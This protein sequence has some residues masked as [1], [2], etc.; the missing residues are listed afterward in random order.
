IGAMLERELDQLVSRCF[1]HALGGAGSMNRRGLNVFV[2]REGVH[3]G[4]V[5]QE[6][7]G[8]VRVSEEARQAQRM[9]AV[10]AERVGKPRFLF[11]QDAQAWSPAER[12]GFEDVELGLRGQELRDPP[13]LSLVQ[14]LEEL[15]H[16]R[17]N[18]ERRRSLST[19]PPVWHSGQ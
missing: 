6:E 10:A 2:P 16:Q 11:E 5:F 12:S 15:G 9:K 17:S 19:R 18:R 8:G 3:V 14:R 7:A 4:A 1:V 13:L